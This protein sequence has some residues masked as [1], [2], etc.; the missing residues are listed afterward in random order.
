M[1]R[2]VLA[3]L[4]PVLLVAGAA[5]AAEIYNKDGNK[6]D[7]Y[8]KVDGLHYFSD[9]ASSDGDQSYVRFGFK[10]ETQINDML[11][12][13]GQWEYNVQ[14]NTT[15]GEG[16]NSWTRLGFAGLKFGEYGSFDYGRNYG[17][18]YDVEAWTDVLP[19]FGGDSYTQTDV[20]MLGRTNGVTT[21]RNTDFF[22]LVDGLNF[23]LQYQGNN[24]N[25]GAGEGTGN[26]GNR[27]LAR[28]NGDGFGMSASY[29]FDFGLSLGAAYSSSDRTDNQ[30]ARGYGDG[31]NERNNY[32][33]G[34]TA[35]AWT[36]GAKY[37]AYNVYLAAMYSETRNMTYYGGGDGE[38]NGGIANK[39]QNFEAVAQYQFDFGLRPSVSYLLSKGEDLGG[40]EVHR[41][42]WRYTDKDLVK[43]VDV[44]MTY[45]FN[46]NM[47]TYVDYK[48]NLLDKDDDFY[49]SNGI[50]T[51]DI[52]GVGLVYQF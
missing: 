15:E 52:V 22:G 46:K 18:I 26:G 7:L 49:A 24:E 32:A 44:G 14:A 50:A 43:Y 36:V 16:A 4:V 51:D 48:I 40:Q 30:V 9:D 35:E 8:G 6:L 38:G 17:I 34:E 21:Y 33:G 31:M 12:G 39:T 47:S 20:Y 13:Y 2:K 10:G 45:Y 42:N 41:G 11:T 29:D 3:L 19:E 1:N 23:A 25:G 5:N 37:D 27:K 28:E